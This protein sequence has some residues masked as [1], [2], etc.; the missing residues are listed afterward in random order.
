MRRAEGSRATK[1]PTIQ[2]SSLTEE[3]P[4]GSNVTCAHYWPRKTGIHTLGVVGAG[5]VDCGT[6]GT[7]SPGIGLISGL[8][9]CSH[10]GGASSGLAATRLCDGGSSVSTRWAS[11]VP[12][13]SLRPRAP[14]LPQPRDQSQ[15]HLG[16]FPR[17]VLELSSST[18]KELQ[19]EVAWACEIR[20]L[21]PCPPHQ[22]HTLAH[23]F[24]L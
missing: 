13:G 20:T 18:I 22:G 7:G 12:Q 19:Y 2:A 9:W 14:P 11:Q 1:R 24:S 5:P 4:G 17:D 8:G 3:G 21:P 15:T 23:G 16:Q 6:C 10:T